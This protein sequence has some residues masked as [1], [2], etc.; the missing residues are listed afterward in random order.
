MHRDRALQG[1]A[2]RPVPIDPELMKLGAVLDDVPGRR[3]ADVEGAIRF[4]LLTGLRVSEALHL[5]WDDVDLEAGVVRVIEGKTGDR[6]TALGD[7]ALE[8]LR[9]RPRG[10]AFVIRGTNRPSDVQEHAG[11]G[12]EADS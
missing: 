12:V 7:P 6:T 1:A 10:G 3:T 11:C 4:L 2:P 8:F 5:R 9:D